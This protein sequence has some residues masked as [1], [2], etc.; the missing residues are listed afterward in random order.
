VA[1]R[2]GEL[3]MVSFYSTEENGD[4][5][6][7]PILFDDFVST[8]GGRNISGAPIAE[9]VYYD[10]DTMRQCFESY[11]LEYQQQGG[12]QIVAMAPLGAWYLDRELKAGRIS[13]AI[14]LG[15]WL[16]SEDLLIGFGEQW[17]VLSPETEQFLIVSI[18]EVENTQPVSGIS[19][20]VWLMLE[21]GQVE[22]FLLP[23]TN[24]EGISF[25]TIPS[26]FASENGAVLRY[27]IWLHFSSGEDIYHTGAYVVHETNTP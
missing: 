6:H 16:K 3:P 10:E 22:E 26:E 20:K 18:Q 7:V 15:K 27:E 19:G 14:L 8:H 2:L 12:E 25:V 9:A 1:Q 13:P 24:S 17:E 21:S 23:E 5:F 11:C 4:G